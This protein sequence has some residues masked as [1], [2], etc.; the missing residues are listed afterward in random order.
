LTST[1]FSWI[2]VELDGENDVSKVGLMTI[3]GQEEEFEIN[4]V[5][6]D[7]VISTIAVRHNATEQ[8]VR[9]LIVF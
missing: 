2:Q 1:V 3:D 8:E 4:S 5:D 6:Q 7:L 9:D